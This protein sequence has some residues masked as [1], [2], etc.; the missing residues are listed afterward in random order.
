MSQKTGY[1]RH[2]RSAVARSSLIVRTIRSAVKATGLPL[3]HGRCTATT[4]ECCDSRS[5]LMTHLVKNADAFADQALDGI[6]AEH[7]GSTRT[8]HRGVT[9]V[10]AGRVAV[11]VGGGTGHSPAF[12]GWVA[13]GLAPGAACGCIFLSSRPR[14]L[15]R[16]EGG[17]PERR[18]S[19]QLRTRHGRRPA[20]WP[21]SRPGPGRKA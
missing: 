16:A 7:R 13:A 9:R 3:P 20:L 17:E 12:A 15:F 11:V 14:R 8:G 10:E 6:V 5:D 2:I 21:G 19:P 4:P 1:I 18:H